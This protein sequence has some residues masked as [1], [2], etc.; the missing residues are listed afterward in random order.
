MV[1]PYPNFYSCAFGGGT[2]TS[3]EP[4]IIC[5]EVASFAYGFFQGK[6][7]GRTPAVYGVPLM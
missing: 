6:V 3:F 4:K 2:T 1:Y 5:S 7:P